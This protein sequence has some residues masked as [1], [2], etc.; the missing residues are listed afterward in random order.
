MLET[1]ELVYQDYKKTMHWDV[2]HVE[3]LIKTENKTFVFD[4]SLSYE[5]TGY[6]PITDT[7]GLDFDPRPFR[8]VGETRKQLNK[9]TPHH[10]GSKSHKAFW[11]VQHTRC[12]DGYVV[13]NY[14]VTGDHYFFLNFYTML[15][16]TQGKKAGAGRER[17][18]PDFWSVHY[19]WFHYIEL[20]EILG[21]DCAGLK[22][23][24]VG[25]SEVGASLGVRPYTTNKEFHTMYVASY[26]PFLTGKGI[27]Q[28]CWV[29]LDWLNQ[30]TDGGMR[31]VRQ[32]VNQALHK[33][34]SKQNKQ[35]EEFGHMAQ[36]SGQVVDKPNKLRGDRAE[37][38]IFEESGSNPALLETF[39]VSTALI[40]INGDRIGTRII[41]GT[42]G[43]TEVIEGKKKSTSGLHGLE[44]MFLQPNTY[45]ILPYR[46]N[47]NTRAEYVET[48]YFLPAWRT[49]RST[50]D[51]RGVVDEIKAKAF[52]QKKRDLLK[53]DPSKGI[54][55]DAESYLKECAEYC[56]TY[57]E[58]LSRKGSNKFDQAA[59]ADQ[60]MEIEIH[61]ST[62]KITK[63][64]MKW[65][66]IKG[67]DQIIGVDFTE[68]ADGD[69]EILEHPLK[70]NGQLIPDLYV[71]GIDSIDVGADES[72]VGDQGSKFCLVVKRRTY[73]M[74]SGQYVCKYLDRPEKAARAYEIAA[75]ILTY[76]NCQANIEATRL[77]LV[78]YFRSKGW[79]RKLM[80]RPKYA[81]QG[82]SSNKLATELYGTQATKD[83]IAYG[84]GLII[85]Y[86]Q[87]HCNKIMFLDMVIQLQEYSDEMKGKYDIVAAMQMCEIGDEEMMGIT[88][89]PVEEEVW[90]DVGYYRDSRG[91]LRQGVINGGNTY[92][93]SKAVFV[94]DSRLE[95]QQQDE[96]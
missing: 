75:M 48:G 67:S 24:G 58:A 89:K 6:R 53:G 62:P 32:A 3:A 46:H 95:I 51:H 7:Q 27:I 17:I 49:V 76:Y 80:R 45:G 90:E 57:E 38:V 10:E 83:M 20:A 93:K 91:Y 86:I 64:F 92:G 61:K 65:R 42:G 47:Y 88:P 70:E 1:K 9:Y 11:D 71:A 55:G 73:G 5:T 25:F 21:Y 36:I 79:I 31:R 87:D 77:N 81:L 69:V 72:I 68:H 2:T 78:S 52:Y 29:Q 14:R 74:N 12:Q 35:G 18:H 16:A 59:L 54:E 15:V 37:R 60:R 34:A 96:L 26:E 19:E 85:D 50:M 82:Q 13:D 41:F 33:R 63:G 84:I 28:K 66:K 4:P 43:D 39:A 44:K 40:D 22:S 8:E 23:R 56:W 30:N 94:L